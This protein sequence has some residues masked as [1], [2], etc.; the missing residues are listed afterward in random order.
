MQ[1]SDAFAGI[2]RAFNCASFTGTVRDD[3][4]ARSAPLLS[5]TEANT[6][7][8]D[9]AR[10][11][12]QENP[13]DLSFRAAAVSADWSIAMA[14]LQVHQAGAKAVGRNAHG[15]WLEGAECPKE[16]ECSGRILK[17]SEDPLNNRRMEIRD[18]RLKVGEACPLGR[19]TGETVDVA[20]WFLII[21]A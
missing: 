9:T 18:G 12:R 11:I 2:F 17:L 16:V 3:S 14:D 13:A 4:P 1:L 15:M 5:F 20:G 6:F 7:L 8:S 21:D 10:F 19:V